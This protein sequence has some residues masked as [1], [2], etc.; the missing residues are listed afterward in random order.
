[1]EQHSPAKSRDGGGVVKQRRA[2]NNSNAESAQSQSGGD[3]ERQ[4]LLDR[5]DEVLEKLRGGQSGSEPGGVECH[6]LLDREDHQTLETLET[7]GS[8]QSRLQSMADSE[9]HDLLDRA[10]EVV[11]ERPRDTGRYHGNSMDDSDPMNSDLSDSELPDS[12]LTSLAAP[13]RSRRSQQA[14][15]LSRVHVLTRAPAGP[16][17]TVTN[18]EGERV[19][20]RLRGEGGKG[21]G[22]GHSGARMQRRRRH[23]QLLTVPFSQLKAS[24]E[25]E[26]MDTYVELKNSN[27]PMA[28]LFTRAKKKKACRLGQ[29][30]SGL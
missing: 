8:Q 15:S 3:V 16:H 21:E 14:S 19:Y 26:V 25:E 24:V 18:G 9:R 17:V 5:A 7:R 6:D 11:L 28:N 2:N 4:H 29:E 1:M 20:L 22:P 13:S 12:D 27:F 30:K 23:Q 10:D